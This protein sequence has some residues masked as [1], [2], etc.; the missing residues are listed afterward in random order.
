MTFT[1]EH[2]KVGDQVNDWEAF[3]R[4]G[5]SEPESKAKHAPVVH[6]ARPTDRTTIEERQAQTSIADDLPSYRKDESKMLAGLQRQN[7]YGR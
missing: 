6:I 2:L 7:R 1:T 5:F 4:W 3:K